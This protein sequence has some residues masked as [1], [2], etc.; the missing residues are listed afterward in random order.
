MSEHSEQCAVIE[1][2]Q[3]LESQQPL[4]RWLFAIPNGTRTSPGVAAKMR[5]EGV[6]KGVPDLCL[7][8]ANHGY[9]GLFIEMKARDRSGKKNHTSAEQKEWLAGLQSLGHVTRVCFT[10]DEAMDLIC[11]YLEGL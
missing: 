7:P 6:K 9:H 4:L 11:E 10:A 5:R 3:A 8:V 1:W 2:A